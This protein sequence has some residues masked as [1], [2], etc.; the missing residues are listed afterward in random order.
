[1]ASRRASPASTMP[2]AS[3]RWS[4]ACKTACRRTIADLRFRSRMASDIAM[5]DAPALHGPLLAELEAAAA[6][7]FR[8]GR[9]ILG[10]EVAELET[11][12]AN[13][14]GVRH[15]IT[16]GSGTTALIMALMALGIGPGDEVI[17]PAFTFAA[18]IEAV[19]LLGAIPVLADIEAGTH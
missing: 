19:L 5:F 7:V 11:R 2:A 4:S 13:Y 9:F 17:L 1:M 6:A 12:L 3:C 18:P 14:V 16:C 15:C 10:P 8:H